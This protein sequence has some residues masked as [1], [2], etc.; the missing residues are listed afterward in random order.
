MDKV[1]K[2]EAVTQEVP[3]KYTSWQDQEHVHPEVAQVK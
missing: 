3:H 2:M 1:D